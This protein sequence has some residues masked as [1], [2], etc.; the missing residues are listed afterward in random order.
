M[1][2]KPVN[3]SIDSD[4]LEKVEE[5]RN[6]G[7]E[8]FNLSKIAER[9]IRAEISQPDYYFWN[10]NQHRIDG[11]ATEA[12][13]YSV[14]AAYGN[15]EDWGSQLESPGVG[16]FVFGYQERTGAMGFGVVLE[17]G[18]R[19]VPKSADD[20][21]TNQEAEFHRRV[22]WVAVLDKSEAVEVTTI[23]HLLGYGEGYSP[24]NVTSQIRKSRDKASLLK[25]V[26]KGRTW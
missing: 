18:Y 15:E 24:R 5:L 14:M 26:I 22:K 16:D 20:R 19:S 6:E 1:A 7:V 9:A 4:V 11:N 23:R 17:D 21:I 13:E 2:K 25:D 3:M 12:Y 10:D 8:D